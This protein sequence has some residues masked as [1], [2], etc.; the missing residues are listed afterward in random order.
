MKALGRGLALAVL[1]LAVAPVALAGGFVAG[2]RGAVAVGPNGGA[3]VVKKPPPPPPAVVVVRPP[4]PPTAVVV[5]HPAAPPPVVVVVHP[6]P[7]PVGTVVVVLPPACTTV[8]YGGVVYQS[9]GGVYYRPQF[10]GTQLV[11][12]VVPVP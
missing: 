7:P 4:P 11:Y 5:V 2:P 10:H 3:V 6:P 8:N 1:T 9:C 12:T